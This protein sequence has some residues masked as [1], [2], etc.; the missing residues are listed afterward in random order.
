MFDNHI[1]LIF[2]NESSKSN[3]RRGGANKEYVVEENQKQLRNQHQKCINDG[4]FFL[5]IWHS[6]DQ[7][8]SLNPIVF[9]I[10]SITIS[11]SNAYNFIFLIIFMFCTLY[12]HLSFYVCKYTGTKNKSSILNSRIAEE[13]YKTIRICNVNYVI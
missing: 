9:L 13:I 2:S 1:K 3:S 4:H 7:C 8:Y 6:T 10:D 5:I 12:I 11:P